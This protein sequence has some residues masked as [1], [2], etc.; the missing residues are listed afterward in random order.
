M[1]NDL[2]TDNK[3]AVELINISKAYRLYGSPKDRFKE[4]LDPLRRT[5]HT[6][7]WAL[8]NI[9][10]QVPQGET[11]GIIGLNGSGKST[12]LKIICGVSKETEGKAR[13]CGRLS[14]LLEL[15]AGF[16][17]EFSGRQNIYFTGALMGFDRKVMKH[18]C[19]SAIAFA[20]IGEFI[21]QPVKNYSSGMLVRLA[22]AVAVHVD[23]D[24]LVVDEALAV[25]DVRFQHKCL[26]RMQNFKGKCTI[27]FVSHDLSA[28]LTFCDRVV[29]LHH[30]EMVEVGQPK[31]VIQDYTEAVYEGVKS[32][33]FSTTLIDNLNLP[34][35]QDHDSFGR[36]CARIIDAWIS[37]DTGKKIQIIRSG[38]NIQLNLVI[39]V[40]QDL[41]RP[42]VGF[43]VKNGLG[44]DIFG[45]NSHHAGQTLRSF[46]AGE[47]LRV[48]F[49]FIWPTIQGGPYAV[50]VAVADGT[51]TDH[52]QHHLVP[53]ALVLESLQEDNFSG[54]LN[55]EQRRVQVFEVN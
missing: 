36:G 23:P 17:P 13:V 30:G 54:I 27:L 24:I 29:W 25:G 5:F 19:E 50:T 18:R 44:L 55:L 40:K 22:F 2:F 34:T 10:L 31:K 28:V 16:N 7:F 51:I 15:G 41:S 35:F 43:L 3:F 20:D 12:L 49:G 46:K 48:E 39:D 52:V 9:N 37:D 21:D 1:I 45:F 8:R 38:Q 47:H 32:R 14:A 26:D 33:Q 6:N 4:A 42:I 11:L 53:H